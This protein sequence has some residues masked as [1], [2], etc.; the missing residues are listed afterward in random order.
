MK[1]CVA[2]FALLAGAATAGSPGERRD[3]LLNLVRQDCGSCHGLTM[4]GG[5]GPPLLPATL[6]D[7][8]PESLR[9]VVLHGRQGTPMPPW[10][11]FL[12]ESEAAWIIELLREGLPVEK[13]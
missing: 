1:R 12:S 7:K 3:E 11:D 8:D 5:L 4:K 6:A 13:R 9:R 10:K 2:V